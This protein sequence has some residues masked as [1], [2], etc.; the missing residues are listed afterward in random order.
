MYDTCFLSY[1]PVPYSIIELTIKNGTGTLSL[2]KGHYD[3]SRKF[4]VTSNRSCEITNKE[5]KKTIK[6]IQ[7]VDFSKEYYAAVIGLIAF[8]KYFIEI[9]LNDKYY[10]FERALYYGDE[11]G[12]KMRD[13]PNNKY[14][15]KLYENILKLKMKLLN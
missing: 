8:E 11:K 14:I 5:L 3:T 15:S 4:I 12:V 2:S 6:R 9:K 1:Y 10:A 13:Y 7:N